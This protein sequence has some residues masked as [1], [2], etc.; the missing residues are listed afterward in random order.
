MVRW[1][2]LTKQKLL[3][4]KPSSFITH[5]SITFLD[6]ISTW[7]KDDI[8]YF[9]ILR[10]IWNYHTWGL[11]YYRGMQVQGTSWHNKNE[12]YSNGGWFMADYFL[13]NII[14]LVSWIQLFH[15]TYPI[16]DFKF[17]WIFIQLIVAYICPSNGW[18]PDGTNPLHESYALIINE[19]L[20]SS[21][22]SNL[23]D[24]AQYIYPWYKFGKY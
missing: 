13:Y 17:N 14:L 7:Y 12:N 10:F 20:W 8:T 2:N 11:I 16:F 9:S 23:I 6:T 19:I 18:F 3:L 22:G 4:Q 21:Y 1:L 15:A 24:D 5:L